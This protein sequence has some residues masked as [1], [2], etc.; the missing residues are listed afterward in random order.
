MQHADH[1]RDLATVRRPLLISHNL[2]YSGAPI[3]LLAM[4]KALRRLG[5][6]PL[7]VSL[8]DGPLRSYFQEARIEVADRVN[9]AAIAFV[10]ANT[11]VSVPA[12]LQFKQ[13]GVPVAAWI[14]ESLYFFRLL[15]ASPNDCGLKDLDLVFTPSRFQIEE[16]QPFL[17]ANAAYQLRNTVRQEWFRPAGSDSLYAVTGQWEQRKGQAELLVLAQ[18]SA[19][20]CRFKFIGA[21]QPDQFRH[22]TTGLQHQ[23]LGAIGPE[24]ARLEIAKS[25]AIVSCAAAEVQNLSAIEALIA[26]RPALLS[27]I[28]PH[29]SLS[30]L[31]PNV[32]LFNRSSQQ[33]FNEGLERLLDAVPDLEAAEKAS[34]IAKAL[35]GEA[36]FDQRLGELLGVIRARGRPDSSVKQFQ[37]D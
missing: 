2:S 35:F 4:A 16:L 32:F 29:R 34:R 7:V 37:D 28:P 36:A 30:S 17:S 21:C 6:Q 22:S 33:S 20:N 19:R 9:P 18:G 15:Q 25:A 23:F 8:A 11:I 10:L 26:G 24:Q 14:H 3:A 1:P 12:A 13:F 31:V 27:D 5:E